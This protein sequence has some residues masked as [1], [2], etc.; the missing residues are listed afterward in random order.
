MIVVMGASGNTG[1]RIAKALLD[2]GQPVRALGRSAARLADLRAA[3]AEVLAGDTSDAAFLTAAFSGAAAAYTLLPTDRRA[4]DYPGQMRREGEAIARAIRASG[5]GHVVA[6]SSLGAERPEGTGL[7]VGLH[8]QEERLKGV[9]G[10][11]LLL[12]RPVSFFENLTEQFALI[13]ERGIC[14]DAVAPDLPLPMIAARD[15]AAVAARALRARD[16]RGVVVRELL[17]QR[18]LSHREL[19][20]LFGARIGR[21]DLPYIQL[22]YDEMAGALVGAGLSDSFARCYVAMTRAFNEGRVGPRDGRGPANTTPT[23]FEEVVDALASAYRA[24]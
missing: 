3:G 1:G 7:I 13:R 22:P 19:V 15:I 14:A 23:S 10:L 20:G 11:N 9:A 12:L 24:S 8:E 4:P 2:A 18:D 17:G 6:L 16:W 5:V 21:P